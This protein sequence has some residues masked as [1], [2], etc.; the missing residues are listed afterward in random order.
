MQTVNQSARNNNFTGI[1]CILIGMVVVTIQDS[2]VKWLSPD[3]SLHQIMFLRSILGLLIAI[4]IIK[5]EGGFHFIKTRYL[6]LQ[7]IRGGFLIIANM[8]LFMA[9]AA[10]P[11]AEAVAIFFVAPLFITILSI[12]ILGE[13]V[14]LRR[15]I[16]VIVGL[17]GVVVMMNPT[18]GIFDWAALLPL[19]AALSYALMQMLTRK[20]GET[21]KASTMSFYSQSTLI[22]VSLAIGLAIGDGKFSGAGHLS[23]DF[24]FR[25]W[26]I[27]YTDD[28]WIFIILGIASGF[29]SYLLSQAYRLGE[30]NLI[31]PFEYVSLPMSVLLGYLLW[32]DFPDSNGF[33]GMALILGAGLY[34]LYREKT[35]EQNMSH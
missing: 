7:L 12:P 1:Y 5:I 9:V 24:L 34:I 11:I 30:A 22:A 25:A 27:P 21:D 23:L 2:A 13:K 31:A 10:M 6:R 19:I 15:W 33:I 4:T 17:I 8:T 26:I 20:L 28:I 3:Y 14:G 16:A 35:L 32:N 29:G 18:K